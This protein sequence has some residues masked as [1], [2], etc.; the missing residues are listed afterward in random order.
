MRVTR[1]RFKS[2]PARLRETAMPR[3]SALR[4]FA[5]RHRRLADLF[6]SGSVQLRHFDFIRIRTVNSS[7]RSAMQMK[8]YCSIRAVQCHTNQGREL[9]R[10]FTARCAPSRSC[11]AALRLHL[12]CARSHSAGLYQF[13][14]GI[15]VLPN[16]ETAIASDETNVL[17]LRLFILAQ[18][19]YGACARVATSLFPVRLRIPARP[20]RVR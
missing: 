17:N 20:L 2:S 11:V 16:Q 9:P 5:A 6:L 18:A 13:T 3:C 14:S 1:R 19:R 10:D 15:F 7:V 8:L 4:C 12:D